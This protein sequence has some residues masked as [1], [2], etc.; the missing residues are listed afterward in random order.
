MTPD[1]S[2]LPISGTFILAA[3]GYAAISAFITGPEIAEREIDRSNWQ[4]TCQAD[5]QADLEATR[6]PNQVV[7]EVPN[8]GDMFCSFYPELRDLCQYVPD[9]TAP[10]REAERRARVAE[11]AR[12][13]RAAS[14]TVDQCSCAEA[15]YIENERLSLALY[16]GSGRL[17]TPESVDNRETALTRARR[18]PACQRKD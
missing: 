12:I 15:V 3:L 4:A 5:L 8:L 11:E 10:A 13:L 18:S 2:T 9:I 6:R 16:A 7:P 1:A 17:I 14:G